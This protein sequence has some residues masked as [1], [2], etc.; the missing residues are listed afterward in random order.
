MPINYQRVRN[1]TARDIENALFRDGFILVRST[2]SHR[3]YYD[4]STNRRVSISWHG[5]GQT[6]KPATL[7]SIIER[8]A[9][10]TEPDLIRLGLIRN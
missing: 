4:E 3:R 9:R 2:G 8:Q 6:F 1:L 5:G 7:R 10:W